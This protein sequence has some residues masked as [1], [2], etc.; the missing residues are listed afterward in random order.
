MDYVGWFCGGFL[1][2]C[3]ITTVFMTVAENLRRRRK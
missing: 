1:V 3:F 2:G